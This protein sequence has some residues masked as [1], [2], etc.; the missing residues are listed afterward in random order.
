MPNIIK[1]IKLLR[2]IDYI[3]KARKV[4]AIFL[5]TPLHGNIGDHAIAVAEKEI[6]SSL[7]ISV[8]DYPWEKRCFNVLAKLTP[9]DKII[10][11]N[12]GGYIG[13]LAGNRKVERIVRIVK[14]VTG[15]F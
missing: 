15:P 11:I 12:G 8:L 3:F 14:S 2:F 4:Q 10:L 13:D 6:L 7:G 1:H 9:K 5:N